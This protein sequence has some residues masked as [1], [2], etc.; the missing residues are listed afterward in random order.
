MTSTDFS[1]VP[2]TQAPP[3]LKHYLDP[4]EE[5]VFHRR[6]HWAIVLE[7][8]TV[9]VSGA[10][11]TFFADVAVRSS[12]TS[13][14][15]EALIVAWVVW[16]AWALSTIWDYKTLFGFYKG[17]AVT[18]LIAFLST[19]GVL[20]IAG[21]IGKTRGVGAVMWFAFFAFF[22]WAFLQGQRYFSRYLVL[23]QKR[24]LVVEGIVNR[25][26]KSLPLPKLTDTIYQRT[27]MGRALG[28]GTFDLA[29]P[30]AA[31]NIGRMSFVR[32]PDDTYLQISHLLW[33]AG[34]PPKPK[35]IVLGGQV[36]TPDGGKQN[37][38]VT[39]QMDG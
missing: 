16:L 21:Y 19:I 33:G 22:L 30:G 25:Q 18:R 38:N 36:S 24:L 3:F 31:V 13:R 26:V 7:P 23:T 2:A 27:A 5:L 10:I 14:G 15:R 28:Y 37:I 17:S 12:A 8:I 34:G 35:N 20:V 9:V 11:L 29:V 1:R 4:T 39:G 32:N 6:F